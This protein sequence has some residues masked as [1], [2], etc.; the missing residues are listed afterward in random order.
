MSSPSV[1]LPLSSIVR[2]TRLFR[3]RP[4][5]THASMLV[6][7]SCLRNVLVLYAFTKAEIAAKKAETLP[8][9]AETVGASMF[10][11][12]SR[13]C[14]RPFAGSV[15]ATIPRRA[16][17]RRWRPHPCRDCRMMR[18]ASGSDKHAGV[19]QAPVAPDNSDHRRC[20][21]F[22]LR[23]TAYLFIATAPAA[24]RAASMKVCATGLSVRF[25]NVTMASGL[26]VDGSSIGSAFIVCP[27]TGNCSATR[28]IIDR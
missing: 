4:A 23:G 12:P 22:G 14:A 27:G 5:A 1:F 3:P 7:L 13:Q 25:F 28:G 2:C 26:G 18:D 9:I 10:R 20:L 21:A 15:L 6:F 16:E 8:A 24:L 17:P 19:T 11:A